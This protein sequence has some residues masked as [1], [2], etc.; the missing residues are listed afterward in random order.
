[1]LYHYLNMKFPLTINAELPVNRVATH[2]SLQIDDTPKEGIVSWSGM[3]DG[4]QITLSVHDGGGT[5]QLTG[6]LE[7][8]TRGSGDD[9]LATLELLWNKHR[10]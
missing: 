9:V 8:E 5:V 6:P 4:T 10:P 2:V 7:A 1:M 3:L